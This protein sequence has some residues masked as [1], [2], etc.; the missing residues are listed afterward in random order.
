ML[1]EEVD[2]LANL[3]LVRCELASAL[4]HLD[5]TI[6]VPGL[7]HFRKQK[8][9]FDKIDVLNFVRAILNELPCGHERRHV[10]AHA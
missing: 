5:E 6:A 2:E 1:F 8:V 9:Q 4:R 7:F 10:P 3:G